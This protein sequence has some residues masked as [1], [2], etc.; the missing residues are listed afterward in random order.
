[1]MPAAGMMGGGLGAL[2]MGIGWLFSLL[3]WGLL[4]VAAVVVARWLWA[5]GREQERSASSAEAGDSA[6]EILKRRYARGEID[7]DEF[8]ARKRDLAA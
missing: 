3:F 4:L 5:R 6:L 2:G 1:M 7:R 8:V